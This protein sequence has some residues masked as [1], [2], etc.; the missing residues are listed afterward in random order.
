MRRRRG[1]RLKTPNGGE[2]WY[3]GT[4]QSI[5]WSFTGATGPNV[6]IELL[7]SKGKV[8]SIIANSTPIGEL[9]FLEGE[10]SYKWKIPSTQNPGQYTVR[11]S[12]TTKKTVK[13]TSDALFTIHA[14][15]V[16]PTITVASPNGGESWQAGTTHAIQWTYTGD[17][18]STVKIEAYRTTGTAPGLLS[19]RCEHVDRHRRD[20]ILLVGHSRGATCRIGLQDRGNEYHQR[21]LYGYKR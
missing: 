6:K 20:R 2:T 5:R 7:D 10:G 21:L 8:V 13:D 11:I 16:P 17:P 18:G 15:F 1:L 3:A 12:S 14:P 4:T 19:G 9:S